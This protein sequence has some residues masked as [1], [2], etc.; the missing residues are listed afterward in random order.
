MRPRP[1]LLVAALAA[2][3][4][5]LPAHAETASSLCDRAIQIAETKTEGVY[6]K[7]NSLVASPR[8]VHVCVRVEVPDV[9]SYGGDVV[10]TTRSDG[11]APA[12]GVD[13]A[14]DAC[15]REGNAI[16]GPHPL[17]RPS[18]SGAPVVDTWSDGRSVSICLN[19][20]GAGLRV[21][22]L[23]GATGVT[24]RPDGETS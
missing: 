18:T 14:A 2:M 4:G 10:V 21:F 1:L 12:I 20:N 9:T 3:S 7:V 8:E 11:T 5:T 19:S 24:F 17:L 13:L 23:T 16:P 15:D 22:V 6:A